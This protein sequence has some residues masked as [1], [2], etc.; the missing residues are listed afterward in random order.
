VTVKPELA[1]RRDPWHAEAHAAGQIYQV[2]ILYGPT[3]PIA[4]VTTDVDHPSPSST[5][6]YVRQTLR[7]ELPPD[8]GL[9]LDVL[10]PTPMHVDGYLSSVPVLPDG[11][12]TGRH[13]FAQKTTNRMGYDRLDFYYDATRHESRAVAIVSLHVALLPAADAFYD[14]A[15]SRLR[16]LRQLESIEEAQTELVG[17]ERASGIRGAWRRATATKSLLRDVAISVA[18]FEETARA[19]QRQP[20]RGRRRRPGGT[21]RLADRR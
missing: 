13:G 4:L 1:E 11:F 16:L 10:G 9:K 18:D 12:K 6:I 2:G 17:M 7:E 5:V 14:A 3:W 8:W 21:A 20:E 15:A 19:E